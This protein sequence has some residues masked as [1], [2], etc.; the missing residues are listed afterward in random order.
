MTGVVKLVRAHKARCGVARRA[1]AEQDQVVGLDVARGRQT[2][3]LGRL[4]RRI[5]GEVDLRRQR[6]ACARHPLG[7]L[8]VLAAREIDPLLPGRVDVNAI[9][10]RAVDPDLAAQLRCCGARLADGPEGEHVGRLEGGCWTAW[11]SVIARGGQ[12]AH[13]RPVRASWSRAADASGSV[14]SE[15]SARQT[16]WSRR[17]DSSGRELTRTSTRA[18]FGSATVSTRVPA[19]QAGEQLALD[20]TE[21]KGLGAPPG[22]ARAPVEDH[23]ARLGR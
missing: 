3:G 17:C 16:P 4:D 22:V 18:A 10:T 11:T 15:R 23:H 8:L 6:R 2:A 20:G 5:A 21:S 7:R 1:R 9:G 14:T 13:T 12:S 19:S